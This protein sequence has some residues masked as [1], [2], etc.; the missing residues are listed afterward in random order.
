M[1]ASLLVVK[2][3]ALSLGVDVFELLSHVAG[4]KPA[5][6]L[7]RANI[8]NG[9]KHA[10]NGLVFQEFMLQMMPGISFADQQHAIV[11]LYHKLAIYLQQQGFSRCI[12]DEGGFAPRFDAQGVF[13]NERFVLTVLSEVIERAGMT[14]KVSICLDVAAS[15]FY[16]EKLGTYNVYN[17]HIFA[18]DLVQFYSDLVS[19]YPVISIEDGLAQDD[20]DG[21]KSLTEH[22]GGSVQIVADDL[23]VTRSVRIQKALKENA[24]NAF[25][26]KPNQIGT[27]SE[28]LDAV[29]LAKKKWV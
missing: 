5:M 24:C 17:E 18:E 22:L 10:D 1:L 27:V 26:I 4:F 16:D 23:C 13:G 29:I 14:G 25:L 28:T 3:Q 11:N 12:G 2:A 15:E 8:I 20:W 6:P 9:G 21:W 7:I 19:E